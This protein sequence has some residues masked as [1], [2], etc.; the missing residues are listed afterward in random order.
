[1][2][3]ISSSE[4]VAAALDACDAAFER[5]L[6]LDCEAL[7]T[8]EQLR[9]L[10]RLEV[11]RRRLPAAEHPVLRALSARDD[12]LEHGANLR[13]VLAE[14]L[15]ITRAEA[16][17]RIDVAE[18]LG[19]RRTL[20]G[21]P[22]EPLRPA[23]AAAQRA[24][25]I[26]EAHIRVIRT[27]LEHL[28]VFVDEATRAKAEADL[29]GYA[30]DFRPD[31]L[32]KLAD[33]MADCLNP[34]GNFTDEDRCRRRT[35]VLGRQD[36]D[37]MSEIRG[38]LTPEFRAT[39]DAV[40]A[41]LAAPGMANPADEHPCVSGTPSQEAIQGD[42]RTTGQRHHDG[43]L[44]A[45][46]AL[47]ASGDLGKHNGLPATV[48][49]S[50]TLAE[51]E[52][53]TGKA[54]TGGGNWLP[55]RDVLKIASHAH[56]YLRI[57]QGA[58]ELALFHTKRLASPGQRIVLYA[59]DRGCTRPGCDAPGYFTEVH[60]VT[61]YS[62]TGRT[63]I[64]DLALACGVDHRLIRPGGWSTRTNAHGET[65]W[66]PPRGQDTGQP[67]TNTYHHPEKLLHDGGESGKDSGDDP[68]SARP[69]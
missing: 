10:E 47:L 51:L 53:G 23:M 37:G 39:L 30:A 20:T 11:L 67:R 46:R 69:A 49:I 44:A 7:K 61:D 1:M 22:A 36:R 14:R 60:H 68:D 12:V 59:R 42:S 8:R 41:K 65:E 9:V 64:D 43:L 63:D 32:A 13:H 16:R 57:Y 2:F 38:F 17:R 35:L 62:E 66:I 58:K 45:L 31:Q 19:P 56:H 26:G 29:V 5:L 40:L 34:D 18:E 3:S 15:H 54:H 33:R 48:I 28:P 52:A 27:F 21:Q 6:D 55:M 24:G 50:T 25:R 4:A